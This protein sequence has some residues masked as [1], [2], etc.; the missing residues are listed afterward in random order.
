MLRN[1]YRGLLRIHPA[2][3]RNRFGQEMLSIFD[4]ARTFSSRVRL[5]GDVMLSLLRQWSL[6]PQYWHE[7]ALRTP[8]A[9][10][11]VPAFHVFDNFRPQIGAL[12]Y[13][14]L[15]SVLVFTTV[16][17]AM[18]YAWNHPVLI[19]IVQPHWRVSASATSLPGR[20]GPTTTVRAVPSELPNY[21][22]AG[23][24]VLAFPS[25]RIRTRPDAAVLP[26]TTTI[27][28]RA[29]TSYTGTYTTDA[30]QEISVKYADT[31]FSIEQ[32]NARPVILIALSATDFVARSE[33]DYLVRFRSSQNGIIDT[34]EIIREGT[35]LVAHRK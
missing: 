11:P 18:E 6:R 3:F 30:N 23:R 5:V 8:A 20:P 27:N 33:P 19:R 28:A 21:T 25:S 35:R 24:V 22:D 15:L 17:F 26:M 1:L 10:G 4:D 9:A 13:G 2:Y 29:L 31:Q 32:P 7:P 14:S 12:I 34:V 16:C